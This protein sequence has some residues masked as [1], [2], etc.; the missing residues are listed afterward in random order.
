MLVLTRQKN[1]EIVVT[2]PDGRRGIIGVVEI[3]GD[4]VRLGI[5]FPKDV[6]INRREV[7]NIIDKQKEPP[8]AD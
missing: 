1:E 6:E 5:E 7:Q 2:F 8:H 4:K 3:R